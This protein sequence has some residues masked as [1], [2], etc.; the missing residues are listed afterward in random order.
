[1]EVEP[2]VVVEPFVI[3]ESVE[4]PPVNAFGVSVKPK[5]PTNIIKHGIQ[6]PHQRGDS[7]M[8]FPVKRVKDELVKEFAISNMT[9]DTFAQ[10]NIIN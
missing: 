5:P 7:F 10:Q 6:S 9:I 1:M 8:M 4:G 2:V 3:P